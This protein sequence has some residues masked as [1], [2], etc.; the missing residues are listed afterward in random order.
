MQQILCNRKRGCLVITYIGPV[1]KI[2]LFTMYTHKAMRNV[3]GM[4]VAIL[5][6]FSTHASLAHAEFITSA[7]VEEQKREVMLNLVETL[8]EQVKLLQM[9][10]IQNLEARV[11]FLQTLAA[12]Q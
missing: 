2:T 1:Y 9:S 7:Q 8:Q 12:N 11:A 6:I 10:L 3:A 4:F 5:L